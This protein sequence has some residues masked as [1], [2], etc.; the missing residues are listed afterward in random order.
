[1]LHI[2]LLRTFYMGFPFYSAIPRTN[3]EQIVICLN[4]IFHVI[5]ER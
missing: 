2:I 3:T 5:D 1:M 4:M